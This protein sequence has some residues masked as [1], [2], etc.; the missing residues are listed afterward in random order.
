MIEY[1]TNKIFS[2]K[3]FKKYLK[4]NILHFNFILTSGIRVKKKLKIIEKFFTIE[5]FNNKKHEIL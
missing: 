2:K 4:K 5:S 3:N 1:Y